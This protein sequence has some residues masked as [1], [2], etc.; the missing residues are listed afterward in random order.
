MSALT[1]SRYRSFP[2]EELYDNY[3]DEQKDKVQVMFKRTPGA[4]GCHASQVAI[5]EEALRQSKHAFVCE[6]DLVFCDD[7][8][9]RLSI[10]YK[11]LNQHEWDIFWF[12]GTYHN[13]PTWHKSIEGKHTHPDMQVCNCVLNRD[14]EE[15]NNKY[16]VRTYG[17]FSTHAYLVNKD[18]IKHIL[19]VLDRNV[20]ISMGIDWIMIKEQPNLNCFAFNPG[21]IKQY[22]SMS[23]ISNAFAVQSGFRNLGQHWFSRKMNEYI[24][25]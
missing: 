6:D 24:P 20:P 1:F 9:E 4:L 7:F 8:L 22:D 3:S 17:C 5:M 11:F 23:N 15:T 2:W 14:W 13:E 16:I 10:I 12:G 21:C 25:D 19:D 18:R